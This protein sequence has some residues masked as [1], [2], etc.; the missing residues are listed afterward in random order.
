[1]T[2]E[3]LSIELRTGNAAFAD[4]GEKY[5]LARILRKLA[6]D[7]ESYGEMASERLKDINGNTCGAVSF[8]V[9]D[10]E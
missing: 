10:D 4:N 5:E 6:D 3:S 2:I 9:R 8:T 7:I 1:M